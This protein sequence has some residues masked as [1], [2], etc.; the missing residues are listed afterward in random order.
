MEKL[1]RKVYCAGC[2]RHTNHNIINSYREQSRPEQE[3]FQWYHEY[4]IVQC[5]GC[6]KI[7]FA[8]KFGDSDTWDYE[9]DQQVWVD[10]YRVYPEEPVLDFYPPYYIEHKKSYFHVPHQIHELYSQIVDAH[11]RTA[12]LLT[13]IGIRTIIEAICIDLKIEKGTL[14]VDKTSKRLNKKEEPIV[15]PSLE[16]KIYGLFENGHISWDQAA[17]LQRIRDIGNTAVHEIKTP[18]IYDLKSIIDIIEH[19]LTNVYEIKGHKLL[20]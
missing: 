4:Y 3:E 13:T 2:K 14:F 6:D 1:D 8:E 10:E 15:S 7:A 9:G 18:S 20:K 5:A 12:S 11:N 16:G 19:I 17:I